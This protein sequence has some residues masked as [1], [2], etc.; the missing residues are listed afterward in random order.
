MPSPDWFISDTHF[1]HANIIEYCGRPFG[2]VEEMNSALI[3][4]FRSLVQPSDVVL[5]VGD[6]FL[7]PVER[8][9]E[10]LDQLPGRHLLVRGN[11]DRSAAAMARLG[12]VV[13]ADMALWMADRVVRVSH[14]PEPVGSGEFRL[15]GHTHS[16][17]RRTDNRIHVG[18]DA[19]DYRP[20][21]RSEIEALIAEPT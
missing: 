6:V 5:W 3:A 1:W 19:W 18:V 9:Q 14:K 21:H 2:S 16:K 17:T 20:A 7:G 11:H 12:F 13:A 15:H 4:N 10:I 8:S